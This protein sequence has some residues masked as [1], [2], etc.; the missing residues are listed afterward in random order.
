MLLLKKFILDHPDWEER[1]A[2]NPMNVTTGRKTIFGRDLIIF[3]YGIEA[4]FKDPVVQQCRGII[5]DANTFD[6]V[7]V[8]FFKFA[9][10]TDSYADKIDW[11]NA[12]ATEKIDGSLIKIV[13]LEDDHLLVSTNCMIDAHDSRVCDVPNRPVDTFY[14]LVLLTFNRQ[15]QRNATRMDDYADLFEPNMTYMFE[16]VSPYNKVV[17][18][19]PEPKIYFIGVRNN[20]TYQETAYWEHPLRYNFPTPFVFPIQT[21]EKCLKMVDMM[22]ADKEGF[23]VMDTRFRRIKV[24]SPAYVIMHHIRGENG[25]TNKTGV[26]ILQAKQADDVL[27]Y[28]PEFTE[29]LREVEAGYLALLHETDDAF[30]TLKSLNLPTQKDKALWI[31]ENGKDFQGALFYLINGKTD[32]AESFFKKTPIDALTA[33][34]E[35]RM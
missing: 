31:K 11:D 2:A 18:R 15:F 30:K 5:L 3:H 33:M 32:S 25:L 20:E 19:Y 12:Y 23:V 28:F 1:L 14:D 4:D 35:A 13:R 10:Y 17:I 26:E 27:A 8:P 9:N 6:P 24:K 7:C 29:K 16:L 22:T 34:V 21:L